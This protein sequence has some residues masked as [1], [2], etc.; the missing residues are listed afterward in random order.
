MTDLGD[1]NAVREQVQRVERQAHPAT[2]L[3]RGSEACRSFGLNADYLGRRAEI[4][5]VGSDAGDQPTTP[6][7]HEDGIRARVLVHD[8]HADRALARDDVGIVVGMHQ[9]IAALGNQLGR[10]IGGLFVGVAREHDVRAQVANGV[11]LDTRRVAA[12]HDVR[13]DAEPLRG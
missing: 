8:L 9:D 5:D 6:D 7:R 13:L 3:D 2:R 4:L 12:H 10:V 1:R 11:D